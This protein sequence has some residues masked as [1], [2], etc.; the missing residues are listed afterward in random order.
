LRPPLIKFVDDR[1]D[2]QFFDVGG[3]GTL[4]LERWVEAL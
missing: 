1:F 4:G 2:S 3:L